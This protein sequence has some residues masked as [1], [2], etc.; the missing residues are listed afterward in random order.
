MLNVHVYANTIPA[1]VVAKVNHSS[2][3]VGQGGAMT[4]PT[5]PASQEINNENYY[6]AHELQERVNMI[7]IIH[8][9]TFQQQY[10]EYTKVH[11]STCQ[12][13]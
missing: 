10:N 13:S 4:W 1:V 12:Y 11:V 3:I 9:C 5:T 8:E 7:T 2:T 6:T